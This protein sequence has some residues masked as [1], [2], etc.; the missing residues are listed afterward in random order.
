MRRELAYFPEQRVAC[1]D[2]YRRTQ[3]GRIRNDTHDVS[4]RIDRTAGAADLQEK[5]CRG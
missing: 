4:R 2:Y 3:N 5:R 1:V